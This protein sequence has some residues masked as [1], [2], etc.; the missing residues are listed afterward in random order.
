MKPLRSLCPVVTVSVLVLLTCCVCAAQI[1]QQTSVKEQPFKLE[2]SSKNMPVTVKKR[3]PHS[4]TEFYCGVQPD[5]FERWYLYESKITLK[6]LKNG[7]PVDKDNRLKKIG[8]SLHIKDL[9][10]S[11]SGT[12][13]CVVQLKELNMEMQWQFFLDV[14]AASTSIPIVEPLRNQ[15]AKLGATAT[16]NCVT[17]TANVEMTWLKLNFINGSW[18]EG[19]LHSDDPHITKLIEWNATHHPLVLENVQENDEGWYVCLLRNN[20]GENHQA[21][22]LSVVQDEK[23]VSS[24]VLESKPTQNLDQFI[25]II[26]ICCGVAV[27]LV[28]VAVSVSIYCYK[29]KKLKMERLQL[30]HKNEAPT[31]PLL[32]VSCGPIP[33]S[34]SRPIMPIDNALEFPRERLDIQ[35]I[36]GQGAFGV[37]K[38][39]SAFGIGE[40]SKSSIVAVKTLKD[41]ATYQE[42]CEFIKEVDVMKTVKKMGYHINIVNFLGCCTQNG[43]LLMIVEYCKKGNLRDYLLSFRTRPWSISG[44]K[45]DGD[46]YMQ[47]VDIEEAENAKNLLSQKILLSFS[48]QIAR[49]ME[50]LS[51]N[52]CI[53]RD[54]A[55]R[56]VLVTEDNVLKIADFGLARNGDYYR[57]TSGGQFPVKWMPPEALIDFKYTVKSDVWS[58]GIVMWEIFSLGGMPYPTIPHQDLYNKLIKG[59]RMEKPPL[60]PDSLYDTMKRCWNHFPDDRPDFTTLVLILERQLVRVSNG[61]YLEVLADDS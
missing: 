16:F 1:N 52:K 35:E 25:L 6:W 32:S 45:E 5:N 61:G 13:T 46:V 40:N 60:A 49:G 58:F 14:Y 33:T 12:Y 11:D 51:S 18:G 7:K 29:I 37:V 36:I 57:K 8:W 9:K 56:N 15:T 38:K 43:P 47:G 54:L 24:P 20:L 17:Q 23:P 22:Y 34:S 39:A 53:H 2:W 26:G 3:T 41:D 28:A 55:A 42:H 30:Y 4:E 48:H 19:P 59:Y 27:L 50:F 31:S 10:V 21:A 44:W